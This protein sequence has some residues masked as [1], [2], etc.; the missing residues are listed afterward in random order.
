MDHADD[1]RGRGPDGRVVC[2][3][4]V[5]N[6]ILPVYGE[7]EVRL[8]LDQSHSDWLLVPP[9]GDKGV[10][11][12]AMSVRLAAETA[13]LRVRTMT[14]AVFAETPAEIPPPAGSPAPG[15]T[16]WIFATVRHDRRATRRPPR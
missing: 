16:R 10:D 9:A 1:D 14:A 13:G 11:H 6:P 3:G 4:A 15:E 7:R 8:V 2:L 5:Q 12:E